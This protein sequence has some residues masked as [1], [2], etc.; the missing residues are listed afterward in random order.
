M[1]WIA[2]LAPFGIGNPEPIFLTR[3]LTVAAPMRLI[4]DKHISLQLHQSS[5][6]NAVSTRTIAALGWSR[7]SVGWPARCK[8]MGVAKG[9]VI[10]AL[11]RLRHNTGPYAS[12]HF[13]G[14]ELELCDLRPA[15]RATHCL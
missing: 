8:R 5:P 13:N 6:G 15:G 3:G 9:S 14:I 10:D 1:S 11:Y 4:Q 12:P 2:R 7:D